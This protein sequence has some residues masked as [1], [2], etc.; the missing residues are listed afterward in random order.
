MNEKELLKET[1][2]LVKYA[3]MDRHDLT[4]TEFVKLDK[5]LNI[6]GIIEENVEGFCIVTI[7]NTVDNIVNSLTSAMQ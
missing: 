4:L 7:L 2:L 5:K 6:T 1:A 3:Y